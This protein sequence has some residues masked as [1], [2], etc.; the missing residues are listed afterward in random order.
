[1]HERRTVTL[2]A[3]CLLV[4]LVSAVRAQEEAPGDYVEEGFEG[5]LEA[6]FV[7]LQPRLQTPPGGIAPEAAARSRS[8]ARS[9]SSYVRLARAPNMFGDPLSIGQIL[10]AQ[11]A[12]GTFTSDLPLAGGRTQKACENNKPI[13]MDRVY[14]VYNG[15]QNA[16]SIT[17]DVA[18]VPTTFDSNINRYT[19]GLE[20][21]FF[22][23]WWS[24]DVRMPLVDDFEANSGTLQL[25][26]G[27]FGNMAMFL[28][29]LVHEDDS[30]AVAIGLGLSLPTGSNLEGTIDGAAFTLAN[31]TAHLLPYIGLLA[32]PYD[33][34]FLQG[35]FQLD[36]ATYGNEVVIGPS[37]R[38]GR[39]TEQN[40]L[41]ADLSLGR[42]LY[43][44][45]YARYWQGLAGVFELHYTTSIQDSD[46]VAFTT[47]GQSITPVTGT[48]GNPANRFD[49]L[50]LTAG[51]HVDVTEMTDFR[52]GCVVPLRDDPDRQ[53]DAEIQVSLNRYY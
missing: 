51:L 14:F 32:T 45:E 21:T 43:R 16:V 40:T 6:M 34:W 33:D 2:A 53:F 46:T 26:S 25:D 39:F 3:A 9:V 41:Y 23:G 4:L 19:M 31:E 52:I 44:N 47:A 27:N 42:W 48:L 35:F 37:R 7:N 29:H 49:L 30:L 36:F 18:G 11:R 15:F 12:T 28:K 5:G 17:Q 8:Q 22:D 20:K 24:L 13:P 1:M 38:F 10:I 50:N